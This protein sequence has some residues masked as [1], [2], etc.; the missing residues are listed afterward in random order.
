[1]VIEKL[2]FGRDAWS[3]LDVA[4]ALMFPGTVRLKAELDEE[5]IGLVVGDIRR[6]SKEGWIATIAVHPTYRR[7]GLGRRLLRACEQAMGMPLIKLTLRVSNIAAMNLYKQEGY[8][9]VQ[10]WR[11]YY[12]S[13]EDALVMEKRLG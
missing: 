11:G 6:H 7:R 2:C 12:A 8:V 10:Y 4:A 3:A 9:Q 13:G 1:M 5:M